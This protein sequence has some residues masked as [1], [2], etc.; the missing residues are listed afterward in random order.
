MEKFDKNQKK[1]IPMFVC[2]DCF[3]ELKNIEKGSIDCVITS[4]PYYR[5]REKNKHFNLNQTLESYIDSILKFSELIY[6][7]LNE[8]GS[9]WL[10][11]GDSYSKCSLQ[12]IPEKIAIKLI[13]KGWILNND[14]IWNKSS[15]T[16]TSYGKRLSLAHE[17]L[18][19]FVK[20]ND[21]YYNISS[22]NSKKS[23][24]EIS[25]KSTI[26]KVHDSR[27]L[28]SD[29]KSN[30]LLAINKA[31]EEINNGEISDFR[32]LLKGSSKVFSKN[33]KAEIDKNGFL[34]IKS[35]NNKPSDVWEIN[36]EKNSI[37]YAP[38]PEELVEFP[39]KVSCPKN[40][41]ILDPFC[42]SGTTNFVAMKN[43]KKSI[44]IDIKKEFIDYA[45]KRC[46]KN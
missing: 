43:Y 5:E 17:H 40:G 38:F 34:I 6:C 3:Q 41:I 10:N 9:F 15:F 21:F 45:N 42:G 37:H 18:F 11:I 39:I 33:R 26:K 4:P 2:G 8:K 29:E 22:L 32:V 25:K 7:V 30:A 23:I 44:G 16:P 13:E 31:I 20:N 27:F 28:S 36:V 24:K 14:I 12:L 19:H 1:F 46:K 35:K